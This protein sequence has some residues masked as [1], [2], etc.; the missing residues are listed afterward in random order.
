MNRDV[1]TGDSLQ[2]KIRTNKE[3]GRFVFEQMI[4]HDTP[5]EY[6]RCVNSGEQ[7]T[8]PQKACKKEK[9]TL[10]YTTSHTPS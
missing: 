8:K 5:V 9:S 10:E 6:L 3:N 4:S 1:I 2:R 7:K